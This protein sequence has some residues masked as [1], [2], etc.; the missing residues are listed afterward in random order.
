MGIHKQQVMPSYHCRYQQSKRSTDLR[1][2]IDLIGN[3][4]VGSVMFAPSALGLRRFRVSSYFTY[5]Y[6]IGV[7]N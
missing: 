7:L 4:I 5:I 1:K 6:I 2:G 3:G